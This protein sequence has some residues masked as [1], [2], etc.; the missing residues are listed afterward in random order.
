MRRMI[1]AAGPKMGL[2]V[3]VDES[4]GNVDK[5]YRSFSVAGRNFGTEG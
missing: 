3:V 5:F 2:A 4:V 1:A